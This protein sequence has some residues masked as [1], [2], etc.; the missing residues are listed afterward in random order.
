[1]Y[2]DHWILANSQ[3]CPMPLSMVCAPQHGRQAK[4]CRELL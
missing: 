3:P 2:F 1:L 4:I